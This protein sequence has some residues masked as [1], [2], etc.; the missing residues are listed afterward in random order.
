MVDG[1]IEGQEKPW[2]AGDQVMIPLPPAPKDF[3]TVLSPEDLAMAGGKSNS[4][5]EDAVD[6]VKV[7]AC[8]CAFVK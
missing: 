1:P 5:G 3:D 8:S 4:D 7:G 2:Y 6:D